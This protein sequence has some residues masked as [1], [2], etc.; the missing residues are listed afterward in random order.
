MKSMKLIK[1]TTHFLALSSLLLITGCSYI[2]IG[3][4]TEDLAQLGLKIQRPASWSQTSIQSDEQY[5]DYVINIPQSTTD[6]SNVE[7]HIA[8]SVMKQIEK[9]D[10]QLLG[11]AA[12]RVTL[13]FR[14]SEDKSI[15]E[16]VT[17]TLTVKDNKA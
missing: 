4:S 16:K 17:I 6:R 9:K 1:L 14:N 13:Q 5:T 12:K 2:G 15:S 7:G 11:Q 10:A 3:N 8:V